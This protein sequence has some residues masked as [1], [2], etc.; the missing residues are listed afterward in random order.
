MR[1]LARLHLCRGL[2]RCVDVC[3]LDG[4]PRFGTGLGA[5]TIDGWVLSPVLLG[6]MDAVKV[7]H[8]LAY[9]ERLR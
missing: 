1:M 9:I 2:E 8:S 4:S 6:D 7:L 3:Q 5:F